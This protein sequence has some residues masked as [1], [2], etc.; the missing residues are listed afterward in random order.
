[1]NLAKLT[2]ITIGCCF[3]G[4]LAFLAYGVYHSVGIP[5]AR[6]LQMTWERGDLFYGPN[7][8]RVE[9]RC[10]D[11]TSGSNC[12]C[13]MDFKVMSSSPD[14]AQFA[15]YIQSFGTSRV[16]VKFNV[17][18]YHNECR[19]VQLLTVG[20]WP[21]TRFAQNDTLLDAGSTA[22]R[23]ESVRHSGVSPEFSGIPCSCFPQSQVPE[24]QPSALP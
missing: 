1:M 19:S 10:T 11:A 20:T 15:N 24:G 14:A 7:F 18:H 5:S 16:P 9:S 13:G 2:L 4:V 23:G 12:F 3:V 22:H 17:F 6:T 21:S 8:I